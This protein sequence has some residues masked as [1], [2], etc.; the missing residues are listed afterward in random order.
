MK[1]LIAKCAATFP[2]ILC[3]SGLA[4]AEPTN[5]CTNEIL[6]GHTSSPLAD[7]RAP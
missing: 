3:L 2:L 7:S 5:R 6:K 4:A 1:H